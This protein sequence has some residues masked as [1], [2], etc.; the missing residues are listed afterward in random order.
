MKYFVDILLVIFGYISGSFPPAYIIVKLFKNKDIRDIGSGNVGTMNV[1]RNVDLKLGIITGI[2]D[3]AKGFIPTYL[4]MRYSSIKWIPILVV[5]AS[6]AGHNW[7]IFLKLTGG[8]GVATTV[9]ALLALILDANLNPNL[10]PL[11]LIPSIIG[12]ILT[13]I[14]FK[15]FYIGAMVAYIVGPFSFLY[16]RKSFLEATLFLILAIIVIYKIRFDLKRSF[17]KRKKVST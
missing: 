12:F 13:L 7:S 6:V 2:L 11:V 10:N 15:D 17:E 8:K 1:L 16:F 3:I 5:V 4:A 9:G 14:F